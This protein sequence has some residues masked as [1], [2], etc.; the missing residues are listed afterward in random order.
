MWGHSSDSRSKR[1]AAA[2]A[3]GAAPRMSAWTVGASGAQPRAQD[4][5]VQGLPDVLG[6]REQGAPQAPQ[7][8]IHGV[9]VSVWGRSHG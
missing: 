4:A 7:T 3:T 9:P 2:N 1:G 6:W 5:V 8:I